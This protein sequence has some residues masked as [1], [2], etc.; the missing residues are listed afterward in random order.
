MESHWRI[1]QIWIALNK[2]LAYQSTRATA[3]RWRRTVYCVL[4]KVT[5]RWSQPMREDVMSIL[6]IVCDRA[7]TWQSD[8]K[9]RIYNMRNVFFHWLRRFSCDRIRALVQQWLPNRALCDECTNLFVFAAVL[10][11]A[12]NR[13]ISLSG[14]V[15]RSSNDLPSYVEWPMFLFLP[16]NPHHV[17]L[18]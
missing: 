7:P 17:L 6:P 16:C 14:A 15:H 10:Q 18:F 9:E 8:R 3:T 2:P 12:H 4:Y 13:N 1:R 5:S 11:L